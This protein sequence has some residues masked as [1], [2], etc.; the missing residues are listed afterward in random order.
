M[1]LLDQYR[2]AEEAHAR[3]EEVL[4]SGDWPLAECREDLSGGTEFPFQVWSA[5]PGRGQ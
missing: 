2:T 5:P 1:R 3:L 4:A